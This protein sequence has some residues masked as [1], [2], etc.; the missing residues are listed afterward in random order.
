MFEHFKVN[1]TPFNRE[2]MVRVYLPKSY[3]ENTS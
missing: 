1:I 3:N 2:R